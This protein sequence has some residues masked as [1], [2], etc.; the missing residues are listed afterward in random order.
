M[1]I[2]RS[3]KRE[4]KRKEKNEQKERKN[5]KAELLASNETC[6]PPLWLSQI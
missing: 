2:K 1:G 6:Q 4:K 5:K 3:T